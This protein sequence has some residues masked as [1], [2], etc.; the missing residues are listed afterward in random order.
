MEVGSKA[1]QNFL[2]TSPEKFEEQL[3]E[4]EVLL[5]VPEFE[6]VSTPLQTKELLEALESQTPLAPV[7]LPQ[8]NNFFSPE[9]PKC[10]SL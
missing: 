7:T 1:D 3:L 9:P 10:S 5:N 2:G 4:E 6:E 8:E